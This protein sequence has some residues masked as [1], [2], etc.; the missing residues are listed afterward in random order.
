MELNDIWQAALG[1]LEVVLS[2]ASFTTWFRGTSL[3]EIDGENAIVNVPTIF[4]KK[5]FEE[6]YHPNIIKTLRKLTDNKVNKIVYQIGATQVDQPKRIDSFNL[7][8]NKSPLRRSEQS[9]E[10]WLR[11]DYTFK[12]FVV[13]PNNRLAYAASLAV[14]QNPG[15]S[16]NPLVIYGGVG[17]GKTHLMQAIGHEILSSQPELKI[18]Y[19]SC[20]DFANDFVFSI[21]S[22]KADSFKKRYRNVDVILVD[23][24]QFLSRKEGTQE[25]FFHTFN[26]LHQ[27]NRQIIMTSDRIPTAIPD[28][29]ARLSSRFAWGM[30]ADIQPPNLEMRLA[31]LREKSSGSPIKIDDGALEIIAQNVQ[32]NIREL[33]G[34]LN[35][36]IAYSQIHQVEITKELTREVLKEIIGQLQGKK[37]TARKII[38]V[39]LDYYKITKEDLVGKERFQKLVYPRKVAI[40]LLRNE[41]GMSYPNIG[42]ELQKDHTT[43]IYSV[44]TLERELGNNDDLREEITAIRK[45]IYRED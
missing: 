37:S 15:K 4:A 17:L 6:K 35:R 5:W 28:L 27:R 10:F 40:Y 38:Q 8:K 26:T 11:S 24:I 25:E 16:H 44:K 7:I 34:A 22:K 23:D 9:P 43:A 13:G 41:L 3:L 14:A 12:N 42:R 18:L 45:Q 2:K 19:T 33:E 32:N 1:E 29:E 30:V 20:E 21:Q 31:I 36:L 39:V